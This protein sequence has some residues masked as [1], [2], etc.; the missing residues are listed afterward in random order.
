MQSRRVKTYLVVAWTLM[1]LTSFGALEAA[2]QT[3]VIDGNRRVYYSGLG[4]FWVAMGVL[5]GALVCAVRRSAVETTADTVE[6]I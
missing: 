1:A 5:G 3:H 2:I 4:G 6:L